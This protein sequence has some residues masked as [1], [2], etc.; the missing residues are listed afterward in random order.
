MDQTKENPSWLAIVNPNAGH[1]KGK[2]DWEKIS[3]LL[4]EYQINYKSCFT[5]YRKH[6]IELTREG[7]KEGYR[8][9]I[10]VGGDGTMNEVVNGCFMQKSCP[11]R[12]ITLGMITVGTGNDWGRMFGI[13]GNYEGAI[14]L[15]KEHKIRLQDT[16]IVYYFDGN[17]RK[18]RYFINIA[19][20]GF[21]AVVVQRTNLQKD[22]GRKGKLLYFWNL[23]SCLMSYKHTQTEVVIDGNRISNHTF[24]ISLGIGKYSGGGMMQTPNAIPDDGFFD[25]TII[26]KMR[27]IEVVRRLKMLYNGTILDH[28]LI[29]G[30]KGKNVMIDS[31]PLIHLEADGETLGHSPIEFRIAPR[32]INII[33]GHYLCEEN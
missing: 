21:D 16:G 6:A 24:T 19:G 31:D 20:L 2:A 17:K 30:F 1:G 3:G 26:K 5:C 13:P 10:A 8:K 33:Y 14:K 18:K 32:S 27:K 7:V 28:P 11:A 9:I 23:L 4:S 25:I 12:D 29:E 22:K 15:I